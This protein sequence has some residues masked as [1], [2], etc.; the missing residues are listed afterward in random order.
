MVGVPDTS[1]LTVIFSGYRVPVTGVT[2]HSDRVALVTLH[3]P[4]P[5][6]VHPLCR[7]GLGDTVRDWLEEA[8]REDEV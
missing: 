3:H 7:A 5:G 1:T 2:V 6:T 8:I 4:V